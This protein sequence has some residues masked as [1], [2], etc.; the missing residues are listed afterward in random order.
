MKNSW[1]VIVVGAGAAG[2]YAAATAAERGRSTLL[3]E[4]NKKLGVKILMSGGTR[5]NI[6]QNTTWQGIAE[7]FGKRQGRFLKFA[8]ATLPPEQ[9]VTVFNDAGVAT[10]VESTGKI[11]P[12][13]DKAIDVRNTLVERARNAGV[14]ILNETSVTNIERL[15]SSMQ[16]STDQHRLLCESLILTT[17]GQSYPGCG[18][19]GDGYGWLTALGHS[20][21]APRPALTPIRVTDQWARDLAGV[22]IPKVGVR[23]RLHDSAKKPGKERA[24][25]EDSFLFTHKGCSGPSVLNISRVI[26]DPLNNV[27]KSLVCDWLP[28]LNEEALRAELTSDRTRSSGKQ[29]GNFLAGRIGGHDGQPLPQPLPKRLV[30]SICQQADLPLD[31]PMAELGRRQLAKI[32]EQVKR[33]ELQV[34]GTLG[35][36]KAEVTAGGV[37]LPEVDNK[38]MASKLVPGLFLA[39]EIL[40]VDGPIGGYNFQSAFSTGFV[41]GSNA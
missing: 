33:C 16:V 3:I 6:T 24:A 26:T 18:T 4:K 15:K 28:E 17:G 29:V 9:I 36:E 1:D 22:T 25:Y 10:K 7:A 11:F 41:A 13:S 2:L 39:G 19:T 30:T 31:K 32:V 40:D 27:Q 21:V 38:T 35:F 14:E 20:V 23:V 5:C 8:L 37:Q 12:Q 34:S